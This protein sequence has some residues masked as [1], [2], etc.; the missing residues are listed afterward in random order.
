MRV[1]K[2]WVQ[3]TLTIIACALCILIV[4]FVEADSFKFVVPCLILNL[5]ILLIINKYGRC[6]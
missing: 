1:L 6:E 2:S 4:G 5:I 3:L